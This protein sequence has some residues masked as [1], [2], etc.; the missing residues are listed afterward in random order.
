MA[1][2]Y[3]MHKRAACIFEEKQKQQYQISSFLQN[4]NTPQ[5]QGERDRK[6]K[7]KL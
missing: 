3:D 5:R 6:V 4:N 1:F 2:L 7:Q